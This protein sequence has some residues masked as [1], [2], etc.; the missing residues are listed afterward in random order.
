MITDP[1]SIALVPRRGFLRQWCKY[2]SK[3]TD[4]PL[5]YHIGT[6]LSLLATAAPG[7]VYVPG[8]GGFRIQPNQYN[9]YLGRSVTER[10]STCIRMSAD[11]VATTPML[12]DRTGAFP[13]TF[14][15]TIQALKERP[16]LL[17]IKDEWSTFLAQAR[18]GSHVEP[19]KTTLTDAY[20]GGPLDRRTFK[21][22][23]LTAE[24]YRLS[25]N[26]GI[27][28]SYLQQYIAPSDL[29]GGFMARWTFFYGKRSRYC[30]W[31]RIPTL[32][33]AKQV[34][35]AWL[36][37][38]SVLAPS[39][40]ITMNPE[41]MEVLEHFGRRLDKFSQEARDEK[42]GAFGRAEVIAVKNAIAIAIDWY[43][44][45]LLLAGIDTPIAGDSLVITGPIMQYA[46]N[47]AWAHVRSVD[48]IVG[49]LRANPFNRSK[50]VIY[51]MIRGT[52]PVT[53]GMIMSQCEIGDRKAHVAAIDVL[54][55]QGLIV[56]T[57]VNGKAAWIRTAETV[58]AVESLPLVWSDA[59]MAPP[60]ITMDW[61][62]DTA[63][64][65]LANIPAPPLAPNVSETT[66][67]PVWN[68]TAPEPEPVKAKSKFVIEGDDDTDD[69]G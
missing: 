30:H 62:E 9:V 44:E 18:T 28:I 66:P 35:S 36:T 38:I 37:W 34:I 56:M 63:E 5:I 47:L 24:N 3:Q 20:D 33:E 17:L 58:S 61:F 50:D 15:A 67:V 52:T 69:W 39:G 54:T 22:G 29:T 57:T 26:G 21:S 2:A 6:G 11:A 48:S 19:V 55:E 40:P 53:M 25:M 32:P 49:R 59:P 45:E 64:A 4:G 65:T 51:D 42:Q 1:Q 60:D 27:S 68:A 13:A 43:V 10:K 41:A 23:E 14:E 31:S 46:V 8:P 7:G 12:K 16:I